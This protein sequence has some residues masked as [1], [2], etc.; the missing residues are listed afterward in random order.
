MAHELKTPLAILNRDLE[1]LVENYEISEENRSS[2]FEQIRKISD[3]ITSFLN[4]SQLNQ[5]KHPG[6][7]F[8]V[9]PSEILRALVVDLN[10]IYQNRIHSQIE[11]GARIIIN[12]LHFEQVV[13]NLLENALKYST[14]RV[15][16]LYQGNQLSV[17]DRGP[18]LSAQTLA[19][20]GQPFNRGA[21]SNGGG[22]GLGLAW[23][24]TICEV[25]KLPFHLSY[26]EGCLAV[27]DLTN[28]TFEEQNQIVES[29]FR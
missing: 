13:R 3:T 26:Q 28:L 10:K 20:L 7:L 12:P 23:V 29:N 24:K 18:G 5:A 11:G 22:L 8:V 25:Y 9:E 16:L 6:E 2:S 1:I 14:E 4:W 17:I 27:I 21:N 15:D 19:S